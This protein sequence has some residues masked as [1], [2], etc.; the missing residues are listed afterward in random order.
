MLMKWKVVVLERNKGRVYTQK[1]LPA[2][3]PGDVS[4]ENFPTFFRVDHGEI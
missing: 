1:S 2:T 4:S 3:T